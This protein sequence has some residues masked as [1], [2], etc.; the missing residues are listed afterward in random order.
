MANNH[1]GIRD[2]LFNLLDTIAVAINGMS[3]GNYDCGVLYIPQFRYEPSFELTEEDI[4]TI[5]EIAEQDLEDSATTILEW[6]ET[7]EREE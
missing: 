4:A 5:R 3:V 1:D 6:V 2:L 7:A